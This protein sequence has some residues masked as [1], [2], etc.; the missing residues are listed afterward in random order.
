M[1][2]SHCRFGS[3]LRIAETISP[4]EGFRGFISLLFFDSPRATYM[5]MYSLL[6]ARLRRSDPSKAQVLRSAIDLR[7]IMASY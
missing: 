3:L 5:H 4:V 7:F 2:L 6:T 1:C